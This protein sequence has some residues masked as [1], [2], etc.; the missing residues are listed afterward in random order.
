MEKSIWNQPR[1]SFEEK[2][3]LPPLTPPGDIFGMTNLSH[4][5]S[6]RQMFERKTMLISEINLQL[7]IIRSTRLNSK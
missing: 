1:W 4:S 5:N 2:F 6:L 7:I 3:N